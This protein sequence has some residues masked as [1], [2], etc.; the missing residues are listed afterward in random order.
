M[1]E[2]DG[3]TEKKYYQEPMFLIVSVIALVLALTTVYFATDSGPGGEGPTGLVTAGNT[4]LIPPV[5][6]EPTGDKLQ[7][8]VFSEFLCPYCGAAAGK[9]DALISQFKAQLPSWEAPVPGILENYADKVDLQFKHFIIHGEK[10]QKAAE[11]SECARD[12]GKFWEYH[13]VLFAN[14]DNL[15]IDDLKQYAADLGLDT[16]KF[17]ACLDNGDKADVVQADVDE[18]SALG[19]SGTPTFVIG[20]I[21]VVGARP[22]SDLQA[23]IEIELDPEKKA[24][25]EARIAAEEA[26]RLAAL[27]TTLGVEKGDNKPQIDFFV[28]SYCPYGNV[29]EEAIE[30]AYQNLKD[31]AIFN[32]RYVVYA[33]YGGGGSDYCIEDGKYCS[34][35]GVQ[36]LNQDIRE[37]C[38]DKYMGIDNYFK[39]VLEMN[40]K[41]TSKNADT[42]WVQV[43]KDLGLDTEKISTCESDEGVE[44]AK[45]NYDACQALGVSGSPTVFIE[46][47]KYSGQR[48]PQAFQ[49]ALCN[50]FEDAPEECGTALSAEQQGAQGSC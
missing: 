45:E 34:M 11:A 15:D 50:A 1:T 24:A 20:D 9:N 33:N 8:R 10:A 2:D 44:L 46:G 37:L 13:D 12:Q 5:A 49:A 16:A 47:E 30:P 28:M 39:F 7:I 14:Q 19:I 36:E 17:N 41:C 18:G 23:V 38:V 3:K 31:K 35:H 6:P 42:C 22:F 4:S 48:T 25:E 27:E 40:D 29:A 21:V 43:A 32:P 26:A